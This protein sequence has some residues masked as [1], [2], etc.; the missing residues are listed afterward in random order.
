[1]PSCLKNIAKMGRIGGVKRARW[2]TARNIKAN[3]L[4]HV[5]ILAWKRASCVMRPIFMKSSE[6]LALAMRL[7][8]ANISRNDDINIEKSSCNV[9]SAEIRSEKLA[10]RRRH[11][12]ISSILAS[13]RQHQ[14]IKSKVKAA[15][16]VVN[17]SAVRRGK[18][19]SVF[20][21]RARNTGHGGSQ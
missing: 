6:S 7:A 2:E 11:I 19:V 8:A 21:R 5:N 13:A 4:M 20:A 18:R 12:H 15:H 16:A 9:T 10:Q 3:R 17:A 14:N 1:M